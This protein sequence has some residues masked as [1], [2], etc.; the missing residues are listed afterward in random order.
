MQG[1]FKNTE[2]RLKWV[3]ISHS[4]GRVMLLKLM[5]LN[6]SVSI[7]AVKSNAPCRPGLAPVRKEPQAGKVMHGIVLRSTPQL[8]SRIRSAKTG[9]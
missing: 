8:P 3:S 5:P 4:R 2:R 6:A 7:L 9:I 1:T